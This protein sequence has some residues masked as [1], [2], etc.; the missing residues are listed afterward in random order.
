MSATTADVL[1]ARAP[2][3]RDGLNRMIGWSFG[4]HLGVI[5]FLIVAPK[6]WLTS[7]PTRENRMTISLG[8]TSS[9]GPRTTGQTPAPARTVEQV[10][11]PTKQPIPPS[12]RKPDPVPAV[13]PS[14]QKPTPP[15]P[16]T[17]A[18]PTAPVTTPPA[19]GQQIQKGTAK[20]ETGSQQEGAGLSRGGGGVQADPDLAQFC[21]PWYVETLLDKVFREWNKSG[22]QGVARVEFTIEK[23]GRISQVRRIQSSGTITQDVEAMRVVQ[24]IR[25]PPLPTEYTERKLT[26]R[27]SFDYG[28]LP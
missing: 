6:G 21:C 10:A 13:K 7:E 2:I 19:V 9:P 22:T 23:D 4:V 3:G 26:I 28:R 20:V 15:K 5:I 12:T 18:K 16:D 11:P 25:M 17:T 27:L 14:P 8:G 24:T 1:A